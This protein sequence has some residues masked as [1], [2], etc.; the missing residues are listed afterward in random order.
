MHA[1]ARTVLACG[2]PRQQ[3]L[4]GLR[5]E[6]V[7]GRLAAGERITE[8]SLIERFGV[9][10]TVVREALRQIEAE[11]LVEI[12]P[13]RGPVVRK[14]KPSEAE[15]LYR[16]RGVLEGLAARLF[17]EQ[18]PPSMVDE[19][20]ATLGEVVAAGLAADGPDNGGPETD[21]QPDTHC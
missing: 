9:S 8:R 4:D 16:I 13:H 21:P 12:I 18:A 11:G 3:V 20:E 14:L 5:R 17:A 15:D 6:I 1:Q 7:S 10:R 19:L 2:E